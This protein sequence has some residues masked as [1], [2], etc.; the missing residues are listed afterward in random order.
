MATIGLA[1]ISWDNIMDLPLV[2]AGN[3]VAHVARFLKPGHDSYPAAEVIERLLD[4]S[5][6]AAI[7]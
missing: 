5:I 4:K 1:Q 3:E 2:T 7:S 6:R